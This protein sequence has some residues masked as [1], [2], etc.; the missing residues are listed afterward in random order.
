MAETYQG[1]PRVDVSRIST[2]TQK[3]SKWK[4]APFCKGNSTRKRVVEK[5]D[6]SLALSPLFS[7]GGEKPQTL[8]GAFVLGLSWPYPGL[9]CSLYSARLRMTAVICWSMK[10]RIHS[11]RAGRA[12]ATLSHQGLAPKGDTSQP[13]PGSVG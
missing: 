8:P 13:R 11:S 7:W 9:T 3:R 2:A 6:V 1:S 12:A 10:M 5:D 4:P